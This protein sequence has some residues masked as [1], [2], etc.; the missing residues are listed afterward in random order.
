MVSWKKIQ[1][2]VSSKDKIAEKI[3]WLTDIMGVNNTSIEQL[4]L[5]LEE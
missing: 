1:D 4:K 2:E 5:D 3:E